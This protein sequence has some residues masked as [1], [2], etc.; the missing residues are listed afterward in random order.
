VE[1]EISP[2]PTEAE[3]EAIAAALEQLEGSTADGRGSWWEAGVREWFDPDENG[4]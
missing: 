2:T 3:R 4:V 1:L